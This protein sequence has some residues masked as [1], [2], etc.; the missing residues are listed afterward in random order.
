MIERHGQIVAPSPARSLHL[1]RGPIIL[2]LLALSVRPALVGYLPM[3]DDTEQ[4]SGDGK[5]DP[6][7]RGTGT[8]PRPLW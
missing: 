2:K 8:G 7:V 4:T 6:V 5:L 1:F 3:T